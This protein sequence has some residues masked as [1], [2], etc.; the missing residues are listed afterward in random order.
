[1]QVIYN[2]TVTSIGESAAAFIADKMIILFKE[3][4]PEELAD[5]CILHGE[6]KVAGI[7]RENDILVIA[8]REYTISYVGDEVQTNLQ[9]LGHITLRFTGEKEGLGGSL[10]VENKDVPAIKIGDVITIHRK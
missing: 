10:Y 5:Y 1:M 4:A 9:Q 3:N 8:G 7:I 6:N 2:T